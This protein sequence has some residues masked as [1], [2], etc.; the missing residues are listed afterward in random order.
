MGNAFAYVLA[1]FVWL[2]VSLTIWTFCVYGTETCIFAMVCMVY[3]LWSIAGQMVP[4]SMFA[5][6]DE[7]WE[8]NNRY[9]RMVGEIT[10]KLDDIGKLGQV[11]DSTNA[12]VDDASANTVTAAPAAPESLRA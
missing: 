6:T 3:C 5:P 11:D 12:R 8:P 9:G 7:I 2:L 1:A 4:L 10:R